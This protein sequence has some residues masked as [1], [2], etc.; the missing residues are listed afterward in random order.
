MFFHSLNVREAGEE[1]AKTK[2]AC[3]YARGITAVMPNIVAI[4]SSTGIILLF[5]VPS[6]GNHIVLRNELRDKYLQSAITA[7]ASDADGNLIFASDST[8]N[9]I[10]FNIKTFNNIK[11]YRLLKEEDKM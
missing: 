4:G 10:A 3:V 11:T 6:R 2:Q 5:E 8:G 7:L 1:N 9:I